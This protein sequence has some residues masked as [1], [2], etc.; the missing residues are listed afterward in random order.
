MDSLAPWLAVAGAGALHGLHPACGWAAAACM[1]S[2]RAA[3]WPIAVGHAATL[4]GVAVVVALGGPVTAWAWGTAAGLG[5]A[6]IA[7][8]AHA[9]L[10]LGAGLASALH[11]SALMLLPALMPVC[12]GSAA[13]RSLTASGSLLLVLAAVAVH[14]AG[15]LAATAVMAFGGHRLARRWISILARHECFS[16]CHPRR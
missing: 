7:R 3:L 2:P 10:A 8:R 15:L 13:V 11:G 14:L 1:P 5:A 4:L 12:L 16:R 6:L 9:S